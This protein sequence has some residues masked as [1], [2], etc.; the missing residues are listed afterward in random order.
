MID[1]VLEYPGDRSVIFGRDEQQALGGLDLI[2]EP[3]DGFGLVRV[4][5][6]VVEWQ[7]ADW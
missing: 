7:V 1:G 4:V 5:V 2:L 3:L 6:L